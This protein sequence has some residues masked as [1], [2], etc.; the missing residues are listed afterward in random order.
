[1]DF[2]RRHHLGKRAFTLFF[3]KQLK[4]ALFLVAAA[5]LLWL[6]SGRATGNMTLYVDY[7]ARL[8]ALLALGWLVYVFLRT[9]L[10]YR[11][12]TYHFQDNAFVVTRGL[13]VLNEIAVVYHQIQTVTLVRSVL[14][15]AV[16]VGRIVI[17]L[18]GPGHAASREFRIELPGVGHE[19]ARLVQKELLHRARTHR[20]PHAAAD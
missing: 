19:K 20:M 15:R 6:W 14:E 18:A 12:Y 11:R 8:M 4:L 2:D 16:G 3:L 10:E 9:Y 17:V 13:F 5:V 1:M 7:A